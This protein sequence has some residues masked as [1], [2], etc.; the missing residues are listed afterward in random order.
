MFKSANC[1]SVGL[2]QIMTRTALFYAGV[3]GSYLTLGA[4]NGRSDGCSRI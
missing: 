3:G 4:Q 1:W 2:T